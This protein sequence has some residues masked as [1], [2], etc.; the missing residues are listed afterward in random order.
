MRKR[1]QKA[2]TKSTAKTARRAA[3]KVVV[4]METAAHSSM[5]SAQV[6]HLKARVQALSN[7]KSYNPGVSK[8]LSVLTNPF[9]AKPY[10]LGFGTAV[11][12]SV[13]TGFRK[14]TLSPLSTTTAWAVR[15]I[16]T[17]GTF[18]LETYENAL[19]TATLVSSTV[20]AAAPQNAASI[21]TIANQARVIA[22]GLRI[23]VRYATT[24]A[25]GNI[26]AVPV[27]SDKIDN[28]QALSFNSLSGL[29]SAN[30]G[31]GGGGEIAM[32][33]NYRPLDLTSYEFGTYT[34]VNP[35]T[36]TQYV[37]MSVIGGTGWVAGSFTIEVNMV[38][39]LETIG[40]VLV[41]AAD[42][43]CGLGSSDAALQ[44]SA[45]APEPTR[46]LNPSNINEGHLASV[47]SAFRVAKSTIGLANQLNSMIGGSNSG[48]FRFPLREVINPVVEE[49]KKET[50]KGEIESRPLSPT[51]YLDLNP[52]DLDQLP[53]EQLI[54]L[55]KSKV[56]TH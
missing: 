51:S 48:A 56:L 14:F 37:P 15:L 12:T 34:L 55:L 16:P 1:S 7:S 54:S 4:K 36:S 13:V 44:A 30:W 8:Y 21:A 3:K 24:N 39:H 2:I 27:Y 23:V 20:T 22:A 32:E 17:N 33:C 28:L 9:T 42:D 10:P 5:S 25:R 40:G 19:A 49:E 29:E 47:R 26:F 6:A 31:E 45:S 46:I 50:E 41:S 18:F 35:S 52:L 38:L 53:K 11:P 43:R